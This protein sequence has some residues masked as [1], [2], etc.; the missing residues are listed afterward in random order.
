MENRK[1]EC[2]SWERDMG[3]EAELYGSPNK[4]DFR[5]VMTSEKHPYVSFS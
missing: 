1:R 3:R 5:V 4:Y 2:E